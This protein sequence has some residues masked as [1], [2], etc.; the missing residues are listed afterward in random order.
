MNYGFRKDKADLAFF[1]CHFSVVG[2]KPIIVPI[3]TS[4]C[5]QTL[6][7]LTIIYTDN[8]CCNS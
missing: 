7:E 3:L 4:F 1:P 5:V 8:K 6:L 2:V